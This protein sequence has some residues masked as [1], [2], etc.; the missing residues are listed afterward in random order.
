MHKKYFN[1]ILPIFGALAIV[2]SGFSAWIFSNV[3]DQTKT[4]N[5]TVVL[6]DLSTLTSDLTVDLDPAEFTLHLDQGGVGNTE[7]NKGIYFGDNP[8]AATLNLEFTYTL[9]PNNKE[10]SFWDNVSS[11]YTVAY[12]FPGEL[13]TYLVPTDTETAA[14]S[15]TTYTEDANTGVRTYTVEYSMGFNY[16][17]IPD[18]P[19]GKSM[20]PTSVAEYNTLKDVVKAVNDASGKIEVE[21]TFATEINAPAA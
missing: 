16:A 13:G 8:T 20:K 19:D 6:E 11:T 12:T 14:R 10:F 5:G 3:V 1:F 2:G 7:V 15:V 17:L 4:V 18:D 9:T 21:F